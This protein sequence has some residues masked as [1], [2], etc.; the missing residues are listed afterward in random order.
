M[1]THCFIGGT[2]LLFFFAF[3]IAIAQ[4]NELP[5]QFCLLGGKVISTAQGG[6]QLLVTTPE[7]IKIINLGS[8]IN[9]SGLEYA[10]VVS[11]DGTTLY[12]VS[13]RDGSI[14]K[15]DGTPSHDCWAVSVQQ[16]RPL[17]SAKPYN[18]NPQGGNNTQ[19]LNSKRNEG[20][21]SISSDGRTIFFTACLRPDGFGDC[22]IYTC[23]MQSD[24][25]WGAVK[26]IGS[27]VNSEYWEAQPSISPDGKRLYF[28]SNRFKPEDKKRQ[29]ELYAELSRTSSKVRE[30]EIYTELGTL[31]NID[32]WYSDYDTEHD[33]WLSPSQ[34]IALNTPKREFS[35]FICSD[36][37][38]LFFA[39]EG[40]PD[41]HGGLDF[42]V[43]RLNDDG[44]WLEPVNVGKPINTA[45]DD[46]FISLPRDNDVIYF[47]SKRTDIPGYQGNYDLYMAS[48]IQQCSMLDH[49]EERNSKERAIVS[50]TT[51]ANIEEAAGTTKTDLRFHSSANGVE[52]IIE[53]SESAHA[54]LKIYDVVGREM[55]TVFEQ[56]VAKGER[57]VIPLHF[58]RINSGAYFFHLTVGKVALTQGFAI[59]R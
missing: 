38:T 36:N 43:S 22:D 57:Y 8:V 46:S 29:S 17:E 18:L 39:S 5:V 30:K 25:S 14:P 34:L 1:R 50:P 47:S 26:N 3:H 40:R 11:Q 20:A 13:D 48:V 55:E 21:M 6:K 41:T 7:N 49:K 24:G 42:Y 51:P 59:T 9:T 31:G 44:T 56:D 52:A 28:V 58:S 45:E 4:T 2:A 37:R 27:G 10:P 32:L 33:Q 35:P 54:S 19:S 12:Y 53:P 16:S 15:A 23:T